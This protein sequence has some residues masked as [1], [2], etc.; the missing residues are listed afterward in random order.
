MTQEN[1]EYIPAITDYKR[2]TKYLGYSDIATLNIINKGKIYPL[3]M[4]SDGYYYTHIVKDYSL[5]NIPL[6][7]SKWREFRDNITIID[8]T[9]ELTKINGDLIK[10]YTA[11][12][13]T[14]LINIVNDYGFNYKVLKSLLNKYPEKIVFDILIKEFDP[15]SLQELQDKYL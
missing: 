9:G 1:R 14:L 13:K 6:H 4:K 8:D 5:C 3:E 7:Y 10:I 11:G 2:I 15:D 12:E